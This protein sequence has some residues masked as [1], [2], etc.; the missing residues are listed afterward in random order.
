[1]LS[2]SVVESTY[3]YT[4]SNQIPLMHAL[5]VLV[6]AAFLFQPGSADQPNSNVAIPTEVSFK[7]GGGTLQADATVKLIIPT[8]SGLSNVAEVLIQ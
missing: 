5:I 1:M 3:Y 7:E 6:L 8:P 2:S 4:H